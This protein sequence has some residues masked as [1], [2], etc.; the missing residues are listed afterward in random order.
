MALT[1][2]P[3][4]PN[5]VQP[6]LARQNGHAVQPIEAAPIELA[7]PQSPV[8]APPKKAEINIDTETL[9][10]NLKEA[11]DRINDMVRDGGR[12]LQFSIDDR[13]DM[14][15]ILVK[16]QDSGEVIRQIPNEVVIKVAH[17]IEDLKGILHNDIA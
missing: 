1:I 14:P 10:K 11:I 17:S 7:Q 9:R 12:G 16:N 3:G 6:A 2:P 5:S 15:V 13:L 8:V 4:T